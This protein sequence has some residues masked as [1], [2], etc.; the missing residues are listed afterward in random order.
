[1][2]WG[3]LPVAAVLAAVLEMGQNGR[4]SYKV[5]AVP[6]ASAFRRRRQTDRYGKVFYENLKDM[7]RDDPAVPVKWTRAAM[8]S[9][10]LSC[11]RGDCARGGTRMWILVCCREAGQAEMKTADGKAV[12]GDASMTSSV[13]GEAACAVRR[14][15][16]HR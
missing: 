13:L 4:R 7:A 5:C 8:R 11:S 3:S 15:V 1:M 6:L 14:R 12:C 9:D 16:P 10:E 2:F